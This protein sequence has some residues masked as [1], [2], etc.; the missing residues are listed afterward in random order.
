M[1]LAAY[2]AARAVIRGLRPGGLYCVVD[3]GPQWFNAMSAWIAKQTDPGWI[4]FHTPEES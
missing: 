3:P 1:V 4:G 2:R